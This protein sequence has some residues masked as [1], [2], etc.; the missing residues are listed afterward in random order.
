MFWLFPHL[1]Q[2]IPG[3][4]RSFRMGGNW[5][6]FTEEEQTIS[7]PSEEGGLS[8]LFISNGKAPFRTQTDGQTLW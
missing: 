6:I 2:K 4:V 1:Q 3:M 7:I 5:G 8:I